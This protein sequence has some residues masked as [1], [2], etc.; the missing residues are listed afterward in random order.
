MIQ[1][2][3]L[4]SLRFIAAFLVVGSHYFYF[5][6]F[7][8]LNE[9]FRR[10]FF[11]VDFFFILSGFVLSLRYRNE[12]ISNSINKKTFY[13]NR[14]SR[15]FPAYYLSLVICCFL[16]YKSYSSIT[17]LQPKENLF[18]FL[19]SNFT[20]TQSFYPVN[21][22]IDYLNVPSWSLSVE[23]FYYLSFP[24]LAGLV[25]KNGNKGFWLLLLIFLSSLSYTFHIAHLEEV[26]FFDTFTKINWINNPI[27]RLPQFVIGILLADFY[28]KK[29]A[30]DYIKLI[31]AL[32]IIGFCF[33]FLF[34]FDSK[35]VIPG[36]PVAIL[37]F[38]GLIYSTS[39]LDHYLKLLNN[40]AMVFLG[41]ASFAIYIFQ[42]PFKV[43]FQQL[44]SKIL[45][46]GETTGFFYC[47]YISVCLI[48][49]SSLVYIFFE[50]PMH[51]KLRKILQ[52]KS[53]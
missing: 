31:F 53:I 16:L 7:S 42:V 17:Y 13:I 50:K 15:I 43:F 21:A 49:S 29:L 44:Y 47:L 46:L 12:V 37:I 45:N 25:I 30:Q 34:P 26:I 36:N 5:P 39:F 4:T 18:I 52:N 8:I 14:F 41:E 40:K 3:S 23:F 33:L 9:F 2:N 10:G 24:F 28:V 51:Y 22:L 6:D 11:G 1:I 20:F 32:S 38:A 27:L 19:I 48:L 35:Y